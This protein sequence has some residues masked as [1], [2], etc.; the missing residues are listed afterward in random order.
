MPDITALG[1]TRVK[2]EA[3]VSPSRVSYALETK[4]RRRVSSCSLP[5]SLEMHYLAKHGQSVRI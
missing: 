2:R 1:T 5:K 4:R 3:V